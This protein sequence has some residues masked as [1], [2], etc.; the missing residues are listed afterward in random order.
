MEGRMNAGPK[1]AMRPVID[2]ISLTLK[3]FDPNDSSNSL[4]KLLH[5][6][7]KRTIS[8]LCPLILI[9]ILGFIRE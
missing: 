4:K 3:S 8:A 9:A 1:I 7:R 2:A 5:I 6:Y